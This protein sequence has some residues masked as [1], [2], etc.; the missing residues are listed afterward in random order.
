MNA[1]RSIHSGKPSSQSGSCSNGNPKREKIPRV[2]R[3]PRDRLSGSGSSGKGQG[4]GQ[5]KGTV[6]PHVKQSTEVLRF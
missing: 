6:N 1:I 5:D 2:T 3:E 4:K